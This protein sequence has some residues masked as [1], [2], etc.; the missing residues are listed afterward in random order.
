M[1]DKVEKG[2]QFF[3][4]LGSREGFSKSGDNGIFVGR[5]KD[6]RLKGVI[7]DTGHCWEYCI[8]TLQKK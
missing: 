7:N 6:A 3:R 5:W 2:Q 4:S 1:N 8:Q